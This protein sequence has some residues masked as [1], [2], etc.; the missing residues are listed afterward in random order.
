MKRAFRRM[1]LAGL[2]AGTA[3]CLGLTGWAAPNPVPY[4]E[5]FESAVYTNG[6]PIAGTN[7]WSAFVAS[8]GLV[9]T[10]GAGA[11]SAL[12]NYTLGGH[13]FPIATNHL[14]VLQVTDEIADDVSTATGGVVAVEMMAMPSLPETEPAGDTN[15]Q[16][17]V[18]LNAASNLVVWHQNRIGT[19]TN[20]WRALT[21]GPALPV[22]QW[23]R[24][25]VVQDY[26][27]GMFRLRVNEGAWVS[28]D[29]GWTG[30]GG[31]TPGTWFYMV[32]TNATLHTL[33]IGETTTNFIDDVVV[34]TRRITWSTNQFTECVTNNGAIDA[35]VP[36]RLA[37]DYDSFTGTNG[38]VYGAAECLVSNVPAG[39]AAVVTRTS[40]TNLTMVLTGAAVAHEAADSIANLSVRLTDAAF[41][42][43]KAADVAGSA[44][45]NLLVVF[46]DTPVVTYSR[47][48]FD[49]RA[50]NDGGIDNT[51][52]LL[53]SLTNGAF[54][55][56]ADEEFGTNSAKVVVEN[57]P[58]NLVAS[59][60]RTDGSHLTVTLMGTAL[61]HGSADSISNLAFRLQ[62][63]AFVSAPAFSVAGATRTNLE[64]RFVGAVQAGE[65]QYAQ[66]TF[67]EAA[68]NNGAVD[69]T[70]L[71]MVAKDL[72][73]TNGEDFVASGRAVVSNVP[74]GLGLHLI[75]AGIRQLTLAFSGNASAHA[76]TDSITN[77]GIAL[78]D[79]AFVGGGASSVS[80][81]VRADLQVVFHDQPVLSAPLARFGEG[82]A[83]DGS[84]SNALTV[85]LSGESFAAV[86]FAS[87]VQYTVSGVPAGLTFAL[88]RDSAT[89]VTAQLTGH[90]AAHA[91]GDSVAGLTL[92][93][94]DGAFAAVPAA[95]VNGDP[96]VFAID[97]HDP[98]VLAA[99]QRHF[100]E[101]SINDGSISNALPITLGG[102]TFSN[103]VFMAGTHYSASGVPSGLTLTV[104]RDNATQV[105]AR[106][107]GRA[108]AHTAADSVTN[109]T[110]AFA[111]GAFDNVAA[112]NI[113]GDPVA[114]DVDF[115]DQP[116]VSAAG[117]QFVEASANDGSIGNTLSMALTGGTF[118]SGPFVA[119]THYTVSG[120]PA[121]LTFS[122]TRDGATNVTV[123]LAGRAVAHA[124]SDSVTNL[125]VT[126]LDAAFT[127]VSAS[128]VN[129]HPVAFGV[130]F[131][132][133][134]V[135]VFGFDT[136]NEAS[137][138]TIDNAASHLITLSGGAFA[139]ADGSDFVAAGMATVSN[140]PAGLTATIIR[141]GGAQ[142]SM[143][144]VGTAYL[145][146]S[147]D[148]ISNLS[149]VLSTAA[150]AG[151][152]ASNV[153][154]PA[155]SDLRVVFRDDTPFVYHVPYEES[156]EAELPGSYL[157]AVRGWSGEH[158]EAGI[159]T[160]ETSLV[161][162]PWAFGGL[163]LPLATNH[164][165]TAYL[166]SDIGAAIESMPGQQ[167]TIDFMARPAPMVDQPQVD[168]SMQMAFFVTTNGQLAIWHQNRTAA[169]TNE[170]RVLAEAP[171]VST[172]GWTRF[173]VC[174]D[175][176]AHMFQIRVNGSK[177]VADA[178]GWSGAGGSQPGTWFYMVQTN[179][180]LSRFGMAGVGA[181][182]LDDL[183]VRT[184][185]SNWANGSL[186][187]FR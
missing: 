77:L 110:I 131:N 83:N 173:T 63:G 95:N 65:V 30:P 178:A 143:S 126:F 150:F 159:F 52:P 80:N 177:P 48:Y 145:H 108:D 135:V 1:S 55:G 12:T 176:T 147:V 64:V 156:F 13:A 184:S 26:G 125:V 19:P 186:F 75:R 130:A 76:A 142:L 46:A 73:G 4:R 51:I 155:K 114:L 23:A 24:F 106:L 57:L 85:T 113:S 59:L 54:A 182:Y 137:L 107:T 74:G 104:T 123:Q 56:G 160:A 5:P 21:N 50:A 165:Q 40:A 96:V 37:L 88:V 175:Y 138:G 161:T 133:A 164:V 174:Q 22:G 90:A 129:G 112:A 157:T 162:A 97:F 70:T 140:V 93:F 89:Q 60:V 122:L 185:F 71:T 152:A 183:T 18:H 43:G 101:G 33:G 2:L 117:T 53:I 16:F 102:G 171:G 146:D 118:A 179:A 158:A 61:Q 72:L 27:H 103:A 154:G 42:A 32:Q 41:A 11:V 94:L 45:T 187:R 20:E 69:G 25:S 68:S 78:G 47:T 98:P 136:F 115:L 62:D 168:A 17:A 180:A 153:V 87:N 91:A 7:G 81:A 167:V 79:S 9:V 36:L 67:E 8:A 86:A 119:D 109:L 44:L 31:T 29:A 10:N 39:L 35:A 100:M 169:P 166:Q 134:P 99:A 144:L 181:G 121:G 15:W 120:V 105:T 172:N 111:D 3:A 34:T 84:I 66:T 170:V 151:V 6:F 128:N 82:V 38:Q 58:S 139:G 92:A 116:M 28:D 149:V 148:S 14:K 132:N 163:A 124:A 141:D 127:G 49:E